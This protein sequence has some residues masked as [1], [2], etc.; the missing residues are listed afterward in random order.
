M[1]LLSLL[2]VSRSCAP[3]RGNERPPA[4][5]QIVDWSRG[6]NASRDITGALIWTPAYFAQVLEGDASE[7]LFLFGRISR[8]E[9]HA[10]VTLMSAD[11]QTERSYAGWSLAYAGGSHVVQD[12][13]GHA[14]DIGSANDFA[15]AAKEVRQLIF[16]LTRQLS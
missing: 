2:Y 11:E 9:R 5:K 8:D 1:P 4:V 15:D 7:V 10:A 14:H 16:E 12:R 6:Y 3:F 13:L